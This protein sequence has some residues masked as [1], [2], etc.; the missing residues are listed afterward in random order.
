[1]PASDYEVPFGQARVVAAGDDIT[2]VGISHMVLECLR[3]H[4]LLADVGM[5]PR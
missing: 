4:E 1:M 2:L 3:A 5:T